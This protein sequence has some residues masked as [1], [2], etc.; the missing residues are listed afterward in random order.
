M[1]NL[2]LITSI[3]DPPQKPLSYTNIRSIYSKSERFEH[4]KLTI[5]SVKQKVPNVT[6]LVVE[7][8]LLNDDE[9]K[10]FQENTDYF[11]N[12]YF[13]KTLREY[14]HGHSK[15]LGEG[16]MTI[17]GLEYVIH[18]NIDFRNLFKISGRYWLSE[19][20]TY[21]S[22]DND[23]VVVKYID[24]DINNIFTC[25]YKLPKSIGVLWC[26]FL[27]NSFNHMVNCI[28]YE[29]LFS[30]FI[31]SLKD[32]KICVLERTGVQGYVSVSNDF[33]NG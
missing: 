15:A 1:T 27:K 6:I 11:I 12:I 28:G 31:C 26:Q 22:F 23:D 19:N 29:H 16:T 24:G 17:C 8:S 30:M 32:I 9:L 14:V 4:T 33:Y 25:L 3:I 5:E 18:N 2:V 7:C 13:D 10:Y 20:F 21:K